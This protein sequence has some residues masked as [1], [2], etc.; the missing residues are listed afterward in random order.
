MAIYSDTN[1]IRSVA[2][3]YGCMLTAAIG[4]VLEFKCAQSCRSIRNAVG[5]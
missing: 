3:I 1:S 4:A 5:E 2:Y